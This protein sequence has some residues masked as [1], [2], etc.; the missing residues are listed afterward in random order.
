MNFKRYNDRTITAVPAAGTAVE[1][2]FM[3]HGLEKQ[4]SHCD[5]YER[6][7][8]FTKFLPEHQPILE[9]GCGS[10]RWVAWFVKNGWS[11]AGLD[12][13]ETL[14]D[15][16][17]RAIPGAR[18]EVGDMRDMPFDDGEFGAIVSLGAVDHTPEGPMGS[19]KEYYRVLRQG[20]IAIIS[21]P[22]LASRM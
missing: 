10:G 18:F 19:L 12:W 6:A 4:V 20:G 13:S 8:Y 14:C 11:A 17:R 1:E 7:N 22:Y 21:V 15:R 3:A 16:A 9:A 5:H 2:Q